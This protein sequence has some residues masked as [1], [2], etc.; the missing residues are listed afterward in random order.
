MLWRTSPAAGPVM[1]LW[2]YEVRNAAHSSISALRC[3]N[4]SVRAYACSVELPSLWAS[5][6]SEIYQ[7]AFATSSVQSLKLL[8]EA[9]GC[10]GL[11]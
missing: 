5:A 4:R 7:L 9:V 2:C 10:G 1:A 3:S 6:A 11:A 8:A